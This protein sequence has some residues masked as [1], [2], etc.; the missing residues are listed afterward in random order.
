MRVPWLRI[1]RTV[2]GLTEI[3][4]LVGG[5]RADGAAKRLTKGGEAVGQPRTR[6]GRAVAAL[7]EAFNR[8]ARR[9]DL[10]RERMEAERERAALARRLQLRRQAADREIRRL[11]LLAG[12]AA[13][14]WLAALFLA[15]RLMGGS[16]PPRVMLGG[17][18]ALLTGALALAFIGQARVTAALG[19]LDDFGGRDDPV[20]GGLGSLLAPGL[21]VMGL[22]LVGLAALIA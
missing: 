4:R 15:V 20:D 17:G 18:W 19:R 3:A 22:A 14:S 11:R 6:L 10:E 16:V 9:F 1:L 5:G 13:V 8:D 7:Q 12:V 2:V 21:L